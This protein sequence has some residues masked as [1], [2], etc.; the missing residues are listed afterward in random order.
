MT[1]H[2][3][4]RECLGTLSPEH[5]L[6][7]ARRTYEQVHCIRPR[8]YGVSSNALVDYVLELRGEPG[9]VLY[10]SD[11]WDLMACERAYATAPADL[12]PLMLPVLVKYRAHVDERYSHAVGCQMLTRPPD[13]APFTKFTCNCPTKRVPH[14]G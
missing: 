14:N 9:V 3:A 13:G 10:P 1:D 2:V 11:L 6:F 4:A 8:R 12:Q 7:W 5:L